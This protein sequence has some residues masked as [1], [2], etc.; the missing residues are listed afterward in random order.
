[1]SKNLNH[2]PQADKKYET[3]QGYCQPAAGHFSQWKSFMF[4]RDAN[5]RAPAGFI[6]RCFILLLSSSLR[7][8]K[9]TNAL[10]SHFC[11]MLVSFSDTDG[12]FL[13]YLF[14]L[15]PCCRHI[16]KVLTFKELWT[17]LHPSN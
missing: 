11:F 6:A 4:I 2:E 9:Q 3:T 15:E 14:C 12:V 5:Q 17:Y 8:K 7:M 10:P 16:C 13:S 1:M